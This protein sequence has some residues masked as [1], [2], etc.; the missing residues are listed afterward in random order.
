MTYLAIEETDEGD[1]LHGVSS[2]RAEL[3][4]RVLALVAK[5]AIE[6]ETTEDERRR[7]ETLIQHRY[8]NPADMAACLQAAEDAQRIIL[9]AARLKRL[10][11]HIK[12]RAMNV[13][14]LEES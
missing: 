6:E 10:Y 4:S 7:I 3:E 12:L 9:G 1:V 11:E 13:K 8:L 14:F 5:S 2:D